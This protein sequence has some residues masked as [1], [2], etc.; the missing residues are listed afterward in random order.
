[1]FLER[2]IGG[3]KLLMRGAEVGE[4]Q[5]GAGQGVGF[6]SLGFLWFVGK[7]GAL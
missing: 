4:A 3:S 2:S 1:M 6:K 7:K 5:E